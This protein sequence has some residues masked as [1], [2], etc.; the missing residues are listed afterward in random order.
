MRSEL[1]DIMGLVEEPEFT[2]VF[3]YRKGN[4]QYRVG[5]EALIDS[6]ERDLENHPGLFLTG[7]AYRGVGIPDCVAHGTKTAEEALTAL[8]N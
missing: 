5:H 8:V 2:H 4:V 7:S 3:Q 6:V 1:R